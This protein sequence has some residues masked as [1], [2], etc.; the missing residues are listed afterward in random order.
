MMG[1]P[2]LHFS[3]NSDVEHFFVCLLVIHMSLE[4]CLSGSS[5]H[6]LIEFLICFVVSFISYLNIWRLSPCWL[7]H[8]QLSQKDFEYPFVSISEETDGFVGF[9]VIASTV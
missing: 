3:K 7:H 1:P 5:A 6:F 2:D 9:L 4:K 8:W